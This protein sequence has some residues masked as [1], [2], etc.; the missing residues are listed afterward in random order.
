MPTVR[1]T[2]ALPFGENRQCVGTDCSG[3]LFF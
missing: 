3:L 1:Y 2:D